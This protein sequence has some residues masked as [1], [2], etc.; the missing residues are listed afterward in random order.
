MKKLKDSLTQL[1]ALMFNFYEE[2]C[3]DKNLSLKEAFQ[4][5]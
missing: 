3:E 2:E 1:F 4:S 5:Q